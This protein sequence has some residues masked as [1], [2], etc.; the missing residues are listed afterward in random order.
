M[1]FIQRLGVAIMLCF[2][3]GICLAEG[4]THG[5]FLSGVVGVIAAAMAL[6]I[7][8]KGGDL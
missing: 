1:T 2:S 5:I 4:Y 8:I 3:S 6:F 7:L